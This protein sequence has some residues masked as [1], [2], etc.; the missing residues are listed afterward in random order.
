[1]ILQKFSNLT[2]LFLLVI[3]T[4]LSVRSQTLSCRDLFERS[5]DIPIALS[6]SK[7]KILNHDFH[8]ILK[9]EVSDIIQIDILHQNIPVGTIKVYKNTY[10]G[11]INTRVLIDEIYRGQGLALYL[12]LLAAKTLYLKTRI[13]MASNSHSGQLT[14]NASRVWQKLVNLG[15]AVK[16][17]HNA[18]QISPQSLEDIQIEYI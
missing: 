1:M 9:T 16:M 7:L 14:P 3:L 4:S 17:G 6:Q 8:F 18:Y 12:Y 10:Q 15:Y 11:G 5:P 2:A 13:L